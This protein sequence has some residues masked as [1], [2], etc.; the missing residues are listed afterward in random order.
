MLYDHDVWLVVFIWKPL[1]F[2][3]RRFHE[4]WDIQISVIDSFSTFF[5]LSY[6]KIL[7]VCADLMVST[8]VHEL[9]SNKTHYRLYYDAN[10]KFGDRYHIPFLAPIFGYVIVTYYNSNTCFDALSIPFISKVLVLISHSM[11]FSACFCQFISRLLQ[12][13]N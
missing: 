5:L 12:G 6:V 11:A 13:W 3:F 7:S 8:P 1:R 10:V 4:N 2:I 9:Y